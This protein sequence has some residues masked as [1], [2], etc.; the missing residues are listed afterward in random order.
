MHRQYCKF[1]KCKELFNTFHT[2]ERGPHFSRLCSH[3]PR[4]E[5]L[6]LRSLLLLSWKIQPNWNQFQN[7][8]PSNEGRE[9]YHFLLHCSDV[10]IGKNMMASQ[11][12]ISFWKHRICTFHGWWQ[13]AW[14]LWLGWWM[15]AWFW[16]NW[17]GG[18]WSCV[19]EWWQTLQCKLSKCEHFYQ[20][21]P[22][23]LQHCSS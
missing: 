2:M 13:W 18:M 20:G 22:A 17:G 7:E 12:N 4:N 23:P 5:A 19:R 14:S 9:L 15:D 6:I 1:I 21:F 10:Q 3:R 11:R 16:I 8:L